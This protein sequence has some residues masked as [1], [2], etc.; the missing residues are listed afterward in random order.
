MGSIIPA[1]WVAGATAIYGATQ[2][3]GGGDAA[4]A[5]DPYMQYRNQS[6]QVLSSQASQGVYGAGLSGTNTITGLNDYVNNTTMPLTGALNNTGTQLANLIANPN[7]V[8]QTAAYQS[9]LSQGLAATNSGLAASGLNGSGNQLAA[10]ENYGMS[11]ANTAYNTQVSQLSGLY[12][13]ALGANQQGFTQASG[14]NTNSYNQ[15]AQM[16]GAGSGNMAAAGSQLAAQNTSTAA[17]GQQLGSLA[18]Q[19]YQSYQGSGQD[20]YQSLTQSGQSNG[21]GDTFQQNGASADQ[22]YG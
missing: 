17:L 22:A 14:L 20:S 9:S 10:L 7:S 1:A 21:F 6:G 19:A 8:T 13:Q 15:L 16:S 2:S 18:G 4:Q 5:S 3:G 11:S 12:G